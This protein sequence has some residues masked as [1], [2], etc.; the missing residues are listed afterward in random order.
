MALLTWH[1]SGV[2]IVDFEQVN[3]SWL[4]SDLAVLAMKLC[5]NAGLAKSNY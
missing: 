1:R 5:L 3:I 4:C 2:F